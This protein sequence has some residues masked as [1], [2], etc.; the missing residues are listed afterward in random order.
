MKKNITLLIML[1][2]LSVACKSKENDSSSYW[3]NRIDN[4]SAAIEAYNASCREAMSNSTLPAIDWEQDSVITTLR[5]S[6]SKIHNFSCDSLTPCSIPHDM[7]LSYYYNKLFIRQIIETF[8]SDV[9][10]EYLK[11]WVQN[12]SSL[13]GRVL[14][15]LGY[16]GKPAIKAHKPNEN[17]AIFHNLLT[18]LNERDAFEITK[19]LMQELLLYPQTDY[20][21]SK[22]GIIIPINI[23]LLEKWLRKHSI[24]PDSMTI[25]DVKQW[26]DTPSEDLWREYLSK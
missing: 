16:N 18:E 9:A 23:E 15:M 21:I 11:L 2:C 8:Q 4:L 25:D 3:R 5:L 20:D 26:L 1:C 17:L 19:P 22:W 12:I 13:P 14:I 7:N 6:D 10:L 24:D